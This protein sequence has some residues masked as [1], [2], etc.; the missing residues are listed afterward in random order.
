MTNDEDNTL[1]PFKEETCQKSL[2]CVEPAIYRCHKCGLFYCLT[3]ASEVDPQRFCTLCLNIDDCKVDEAPLVDVEGQ[4]HR[5]RVL[6]PVGNAFTAELKLIS[7]MSED[8]LKIYVAQYKALV[9]D[10][11]QITTFRRIN[12]AQAEHALLDKGIKMIT[13]A[14]GQVSFP[15]R[16]KAVKPVPKKKPTTDDSLASKLRKAGITPAMLQAIID[17]KKK[18]A[19]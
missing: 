11:E 15:S 5:G 2:E 6:H 19:A 17:S 3:H 13:D 9:R 12:L 7:E 16:P 8:E 14:G 10:A 4:R 18:G 1:V